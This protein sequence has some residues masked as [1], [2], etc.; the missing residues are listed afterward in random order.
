M[1][2]TLNPNLA[3]P[4][5]RKGKRGWEEGMMKNPRDKR[6]GGGKLR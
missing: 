1:K 2:P 6:V 3:T 5:L 4:V